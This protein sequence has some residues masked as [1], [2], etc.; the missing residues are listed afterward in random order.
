MTGDENAR[1]VPWLKTSEDTAACRLFLSPSET[2]RPETR[3]DS[4]VFDMS[5]ILRD[6]DLLVWFAWHLTAVWLT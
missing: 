6:N 2:F 5:N 4:L 3:C 1:H